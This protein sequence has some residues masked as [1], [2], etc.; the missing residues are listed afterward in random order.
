MYVWAMRDKQSEW[1]TVRSFRASGH[2]TFSLLVEAVCEPLISIRGS[3]IRTPGEVVAALA[4][5]LVLAAPA[6]KVWVDFENLSLVLG[7]HDIA[8][9]MSLL[10]RSLGLTAREVIPVM[11][12]SSGPATRRAVHT[13]SQMHGTGFCLRV[14]GLSRLGDAATAARDFIDDSGHSLSQIDLV[15]D[16][17]DL[18]RIVTHA[19]LRSVL[20]FAALV[21]SWSHL[22]GS[23]PSSVTHLSPD[24]YE[25]SLERS[26]WSVWKDDVLDESE[27]GRAPD[28]GDYATQSAVYGISPGFAGSP[29]VRYTVDESFRILRGRGG[30]KIDFSQFVGHARFLQRQPY[31]R[32]RV[33]TLGDD[34][35]DRIA[36]GTE[37]TGNLS[38]WRVASLQRHVRLA[39][40]QSVAFRENLQRRALAL[41][42]R[43]IPSFRRQQ[44]SEIP[45]PPRSS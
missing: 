25:H 18:P 32:A 6:T 17:A 3:R 20:P 9:M 8:E 39:S 41:G 23:F 34:Y 40:V 2:L 22:A 30:D 4:Q 38:T 11:R 27:P 1:N 37:G 7:D 24:D 16:A 33:D 14:V 28:Y 26:E 15:T 13:W 43:R 45:S 12:T 42:K 31:F 21:R 5:N 29:T 36:L 10:S 19:D 44:P 35:V